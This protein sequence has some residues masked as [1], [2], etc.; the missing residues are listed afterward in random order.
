MPVRLVP[1]MVIGVPPVAVSLL[2]LRLV[3]V[4]AAVK[5]RSSAEDVVEVPSLSVRLTSTVPADPA[6]ATREN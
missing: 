5:S 1:V 4:G 6:G 2:L 3:M